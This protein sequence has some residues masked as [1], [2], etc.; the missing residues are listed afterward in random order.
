M[1]VAIDKPRRHGAAR[2]PYHPGLLSHQRFQVGKTTMG[3]NT[4]PRDRHSVAFGMAKDGTV[5]QNEISFFESNHRQL[6][7]PPATLRRRL[8]ARHPQADLRAKPVSSVGRRKRLRFLDFHFSIATLKP[9][10]TRLVTQDLGTT[11]FT[12]VTLPQYIRHCPKLLESTVSPIIRPN[13]L[14]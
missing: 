11:G 12:Q 6:P 2:K 10:G 3:D 8:A 7:I 13:H 5:V 4:V 14:P 9:T 1:K